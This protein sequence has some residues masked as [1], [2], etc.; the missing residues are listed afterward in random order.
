MTIVIDDKFTEASTVFLTDH[1]PTDVGTGWTEIERTGTSRAQ[2]F[3]PTDTIFAPA[4]VDDRSL[5]TAQGTYTSADYDVEIQLA[6]FNPL[7]SENPFILLA[8]VA[9]SSNYYAALVY[10]NAGTDLYIGKKVATTWATLNSAD[11]DLALTEVMKFELRGTALKVYL[12]NV[13]KVATTDGDLTAAGEAGLGWGNVRVSTDNIDNDWD[14]D[15]FLVTEFAIDDSSAD[16]PTLM[17]GQHQ[18]VYDP[19]EIIGY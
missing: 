12:D 8:R 19:V 11:T 4:E 15:N 2:I 6:E 14:N 5:Y 1:T 17:P 13:E 3:G 16:T 9:D 7:G 18:P 10:K